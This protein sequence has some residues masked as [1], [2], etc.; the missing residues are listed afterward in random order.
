MLPS[1]KNLRIYHSSSV[2]WR[3]WRY[4]IT[5]VVGLRACRIFAFP[6]PAKVY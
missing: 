4:R 3:S 1:G 2:A 6:G 5:W